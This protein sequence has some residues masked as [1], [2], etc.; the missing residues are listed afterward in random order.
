MTVFSV[1]IFGSLS[2]GRWGW[3]SLDVFE[4]RVDA[5]ASARDIAREWRRVRVAQRPQASWKVQR[6]LVTWTDG[7][8]KT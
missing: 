7:K 1:E 3:N 2:A 4:D 6:V 5:I 8:R